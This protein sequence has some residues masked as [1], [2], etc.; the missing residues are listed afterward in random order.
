MLLVGLDSKA[1]KDA[2][3]ISNMSDGALAY[4][5]LQSSEVAMNRRRVGTARAKGCQNT[6]RRTY[7]QSGQSKASLVKLSKDSSA[8]QSGWFACITLILAKFLMFR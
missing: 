5:L 2:E 7:M 4:R 1:M 6:K 3:R 8:T